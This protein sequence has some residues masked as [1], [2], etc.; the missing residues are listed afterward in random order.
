MYCYNISGG[1]QLWKGLSHGM[2]V[3][4]WR[5]IKTGTRTTAGLSEEGSA[6]QLS[7]LFH[8][9]PPHTFLWPLHLV[10]AAA[11]R[12]GWRCGSLTLHFHGP[13]IKKSQVQLALTKGLGS[14]CLAPHEERESGWWCCVD[15]GNLV[16]N[17]TLTHVPGARYPPPPPPAQAHAPTYSGLGAGV[18]RRQTHL[19]FLLT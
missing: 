12:K 17:P 3:F 10:I 16:T 14:R 4:N 6:D 18:C 1:H 7:F 5:Y 11:G 15:R 8:P 2:R 19:F 9:H 13:L